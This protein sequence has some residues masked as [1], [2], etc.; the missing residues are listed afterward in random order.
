M[1]LLHKLSNIVSPHI[2]VDLGT[3]N[4]IIYVRD[5]GIV[6]NEPSYISVKK[7][8][9]GKYEVL[10]VGNE[11]KS[12]L[13][14]EPKGVRVIRPLKE[15]MI[16]DFEA[17]EK[18][19]QEFF[20]KIPNFNQFFSSPYVLCC[21]PTNSTNIE[22]KSIKE[23]FY[24]IGAKNVDL[25]EE[26]IAAAIGANMPIDMGRGNLIVDIGG[27]TTEIAS[28]S[29]NG[30]S[31]SLSLKV[32]GDHFDE[33]IIKFARE[34]Y[35]KILSYSSTEKLKFKLAEAILSKH[36]KTL[37]VDVTCQ[38]TLLPEKMVF[39]NRDINEAIQEPLIK[40]VEG[41]KEIIN[42]SPQDLKK[43][44][45]NYGGVITGG[46][47]KIIG[48]QHYLSN[49]TKCPF[50]VANNSEFSVVYGGAKVLELKRNRKKKQIISSP[51]Q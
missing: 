18:M 12:I 16:S 50:R 36:K 7:N 30:I 14:R 29:L 33:A 37:E 51:N 8:Q 47:A 25:I 42:E 13:D 40:M 2:T 38:E 9:N 41:V 31:S 4:T 26:P 32:G 11:A 5:I 35:K 20:K 49:N 23:A 39:S 28:I 1:N 45:L 46:G 24:S 34:R 43:D 27:G 15:G 21:I 17:S 44:F 22:R 6:L 19:I 3:A 10:S 48:I